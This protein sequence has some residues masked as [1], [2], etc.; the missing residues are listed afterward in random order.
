MAREKSVSHPTGEE[1]GERRLKFIDCEKP[2]APE[3]V[4]LKHDR[5]RLSESSAIVNKQDGVA[6][7][8]GERLMLHYQEAAWADGEAQLLKQFS[9]AG[10]ARRFFWIDQSAGN[11]PG[12]LVDRFDDKDAV[13]SV[14]YECARPEIPSWQLPIERM[15]VEWGPV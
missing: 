10:T 5:P 8:W 6:A 13:I 1:W 15:H 9:G 2:K 3:L 12:A 7:W 4:T 11:L 14:G